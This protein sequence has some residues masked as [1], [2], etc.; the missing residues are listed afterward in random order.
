LPYIQSEHAQ[1][2]INPKIHEDGVEVFILF[3]FLGFFS[4]HN[5]VKEAPKWG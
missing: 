1:S 2:T 4:P 5:N 3:Q